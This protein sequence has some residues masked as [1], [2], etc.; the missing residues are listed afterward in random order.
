MS[1]TNTNTM[2]KDERAAQAKAE[3]EAKARIVAEAG[4]KAREERKAREAD[5]GFCVVVVNGGLAVAETTATMGRREASESE[6]ARAKLLRLKGL[7]AD[8]SLPGLT[9]EEAL[10]IV[11]RDRRRKRRR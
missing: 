1:S 5:K 8:G 4:R 2:T 9:R 11:A 3:A 6:R 7:R 10:A